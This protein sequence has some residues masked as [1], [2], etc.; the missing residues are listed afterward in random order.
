MR[1]VAGLFLGGL[2]ALASLTACWGV[3]EADKHIDAARDATCTE[4]VDV[5]S[6]ARE[7]EYLSPEELDRVLDVLA[8]EEAERCPLE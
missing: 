6:A 5:A 7:D 8:A 3:D 4:L 2:L 1:R